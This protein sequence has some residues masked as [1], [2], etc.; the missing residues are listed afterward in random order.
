M[1]LDILHDNWG[2]YTHTEVENA[3]KALLA[4]MLQ[5]IEDAGIPADGVT[6]DMLAQSLRT[7]IN[8]K[9]SKPG[10][11]IPASD[12][13]GN[14]PS[15][16]LA[17]AVQTSLA[18]AD[19][20]LQ[21]VKDSS[22]HL[23]VP[24]NGVVTLP[25][26]EGGGS[27]VTVDEAMSS[28]SV[29][30]VQNRVIKAYVDT[31]IAA[32]VNGAPA[33]LDTLKELADAL[34]DDEDAIAA[35]TNAIAAKANAADLASVATSGSYND[36]SNKPTIPTKFSDLVDDSDYI[37]A[38]DVASIVVGSA[39]VVI[40]ETPSH[41]CITFVTTSISFT[42]NTTMSLY[43]GQKVGTLT[44]SG[45]HLK[46]DITLTVPAN[47]TAQVSG[48]T[49]TQSITIPQT[50]GEV[51]GVSVT[52]TYTGADSGSYNGSITATSGSTTESVGLVYSQYQ[53]AT[54]I[55]GT[56]GTI[57]AAMGSPRIGELNVSGVN[58]EG[59]ITASV[60]SGDFTICATQNGTYGN[61]AT[62]SKSSAE[63]SGGATLYVK[64]TPS[65]GTSTASGTLTLTTPRDGVNL[66]K[67]VTLAGAVVSLTVSESSLSFSTAAGTPVTQTFTVQG[68]NLSDDISISVSGTGFSVSPAT[69]DKDDVGT[70]QT[71]TVT[72]NPSA[73]GTN[74]GTVT[75]QSSGLSE[76]ITLS[77]TAAEVPNFSNDNN[78]RLIIGGI[79]YGVISDGNG[80]WKEELA[81]Y[82]KEFSS[83]A[84]SSAGRYTGEVIIPSKIN[85]LLDGN[86]TEFEV[87]TINAHAFNSS[88]GMTKLVIPDSVTSAGAAFL[89]LASGNLKY[90]SFGNGLKNS[91]S[92]TTIPTSAGISPVVRTGLTYLDFG[93][94]IKRFTGM[95]FRMA[96]GGT[97]VLRS[98][99][100]VG[101]LPSALNSNS[102]N[103][104]APAIVDGIVKVPSSLVPSYQG[105]SGW[106]VP[107]DN[108]YYMVEY[109]NILAIQ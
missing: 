67:T 66:S 88:P 80:G 95:E 61:S 24:T 68:A 101:A 107:T 11:G 79:A 87:T 38:E 71:V 94:G 3:L 33:A 27:D 97:V 14:I 92:E 32:L 19:N 59:D 12:L 86:P 36:L 1:A 81:V 57:N 55:A 74:T 47:F 37:K 82:N 2:P 40:T 49:A 100:V 53:G 63:A 35:L 91:T 64:Y 58:L 13:E 44:V 60:G 108:G 41:I 99:S 46:Q 109:D 98:D 23:L 102:N 4:R 50:G 72:Y 15:S 9:Y 16:K 56:I 39:D 6:A 21:G 89:Y 84:P 90:L 106:G 83:A 28:T 93:T 30:A 22:G 105:A 73:A 75:I 43:A 20:S 70:A 42:P 10:T 48:G 7:L 34:G 31:A 18:K 65:S 45:T 17:Q 8:G 69:I 54:I 52:I 51:T 62:I 77:G 26:S 85:A 78:H 25:E 103:N 76:Q 29:N 5:D 96:V 104:Y